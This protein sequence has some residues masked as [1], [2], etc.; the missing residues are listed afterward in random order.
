MPSSP[1]DAKIE[2]L[3]NLKDNG[4]PVPPAVRRDDRNFFDETEY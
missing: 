4:K 3:E 1:I 2:L